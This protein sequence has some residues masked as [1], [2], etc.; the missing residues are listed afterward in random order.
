MLCPKI[1][2]RA[3]DWPRLPSAHP[4]DGGPPK[5]FKRENLKFGLKF[6]VCT[7]ITSGLM[8]ISSQI[9]IQTTCRELGVIMWVRFLDGLPPKIWDGEKRSKSGEISDNF[10]LWSR[11]SPERIHKSKIEN[12]K[13][14]SS[15][16]TP[17]TLGEKRWWT[18]VHKQISYW[19]AYWPTQV[20]CSGAR[21]YFGPY[22]V[23]C[24]QIFIR[25]TNCRRLANAHPNWDGVPP[26]K[27]NDENLKFGLKFSVCAL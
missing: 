20:D 13:S 26:K 2:I 21:L 8:G 3:R 1:F 4:K 10:R 5:N 22:G 16:T 18:S 15:T 25:A 6:S 12:R 9:F 23:M 19:R 24:P 27:N 17:P 7:S 14:S 11:M